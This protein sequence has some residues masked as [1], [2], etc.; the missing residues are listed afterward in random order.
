MKRFSRSLSGKCKSKPKE[1]SS[2]VRMT[3]VKKTGVN[4]CWRE[5][6]EKGTHVHTV[7][8]DAN[9]LGTMENSMELPQKKLNRTTL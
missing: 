1:I 3:T 2:L 8:G 5:Y 9:W 7:G 4:K 6:G